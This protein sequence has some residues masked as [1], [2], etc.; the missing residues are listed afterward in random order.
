MG[1]KFTSLNGRFSDDMYFAYL[2]NQLR[3]SYSDIDGDNQPY[4]LDFVH[5]GKKA[6][7]N[8]KPL[9]E[10]ILN[11]D[12]FFGGVSVA[13]ERVIYLGRCLYHGIEPKLSSWEKTHLVWGKRHLAKKPDP[14]YKIHDV[15]VRGTYYSELYD[16]YVEVRYITN[17]VAKT[18]AKTDILIGV[19]QVVFENI[20]NE[21][22]LS[23]NVA[24]FKAL[25]FK[26]VGMED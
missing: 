20:F 19:P 4:S 13:K 24:D 2:G 10:N 26:L 8:S 25:G 18:G 7:L 17:A 6:K 5:R 14:T 11:V 3:L 16:V 12:E 15:Y 21:Q 9:M 22:I 1:L 23:R